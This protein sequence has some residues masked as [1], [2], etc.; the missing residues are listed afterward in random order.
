MALR[1]AQE[2]KVSI[3]GAMEA[4]ARTVR[5]AR[6]RAGET[7]KRRSA[8]GKKNVSSLTAFAY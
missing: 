2:R 3:L 4:R 7:V 8:A 5:E 6:A 1:P